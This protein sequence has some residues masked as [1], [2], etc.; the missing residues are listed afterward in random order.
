MT[1]P[2]APADLGAEGRRLWRDVRRAY[3]LDPGEVV[4]L[5]AACRTVDELARIVDELAGAPIVVPGSKGQPTA[6]RLLAEVRAH[7]RSLEQIVRALALPARGEEVG[8]QRSPA[9]VAAAH[10]RW[11]RAGARSAREAGRDGAAS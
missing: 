7:R 1:A 5:G 8:R 4:L 11:R 9:A 6:N 2:R 3:Q 10:T